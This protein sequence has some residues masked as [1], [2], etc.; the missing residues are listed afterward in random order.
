MRT[1]SNCD[2]AVFRF[3]SVHAQCNLTN[4]SLIPLKWND[5]W[6]NN[7]SVESDRRSDTGD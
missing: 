5:D 6:K 2:L 7:L 4:F 3:S 1:V